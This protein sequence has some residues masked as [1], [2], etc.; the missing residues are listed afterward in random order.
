MRRL[1]NAPGF[2]QPDPAPPVVIAAFGPKM[3]H[4]AGRVGD[5]INTPAQHPR[6]REVVTIARDACMD[7]GRDPA[8]FLVT[9]F[10]EFHE[11]W[12]EVDS[13]ARAE[14]AALGVD[15][16]ILYVGPPFDLALRGVTVR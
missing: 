13:P 3:A 1:W 14:L 7:V 9:V 11:R 10:S 15:R 16:L 12:L 4:L 2:L 5:G 8:R 6:L